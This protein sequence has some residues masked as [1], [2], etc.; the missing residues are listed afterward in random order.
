M[1]IDSRVEP[2]VRNTIHTAV[3][4]DFWKL[5]K[6]LQSFPDDE[7]AQK[8]IELGVSLIYVLMI[9]IHEGMPSDDEIQGLAAEVARAEAWAMPT[10]EQVTTFLRHIMNGKPFAGVVPVEDVVILTFVVAA[11]LLSSCRRDDEEWWDYLDRVEA[12]LEAVYPNP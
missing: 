7:A 1:K 5:E 12:V 10:E 3:I 6:A 2:L 9:D 8:A 4:G 11:H